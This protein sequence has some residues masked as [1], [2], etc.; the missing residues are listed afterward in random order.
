MAHVSTCQPSEQGA[1][2][3]VLR[4]RTPPSS[5]FELERPRIACSTFAPRRGRGS[6]VTSS[7]CGLRAEEDGSDSSSTTTSAAGTAGCG[8][9]RRGLGQ[10]AGMSPDGCAAV[11]QE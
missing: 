4:H 10:G 11:E 8:E 6:G 7:L 3:G 5:D 9:P 1:A 2:A